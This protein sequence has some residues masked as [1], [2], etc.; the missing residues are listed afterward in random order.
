M[1]PFYHVVRHH[2]SKVSS[3]YQIIYSA[4]VLNLDFPDCITE[5]V[6]MAKKGGFYTEVSQR[7]RTLIPSCS[8][9]SHYWK[10]LFIYYWVD[11]GLG[12]GS[13]VKNKCHI[14]MCSLISKTHTHMSTCTRKRT[15]TYVCLYTKWKQ[16]GLFDM[17]KWTSGG[18]C[19][20][21]YEGKKCEQSTTHMC[22]N[23]E[24]TCYFVCLFKST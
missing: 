20:E 11:P 2:L 18:S 17:R 6:N 4:C 7:V 3:L 8:C 9:H 5:A 22:E 19:G 1:F 15:H 13:V 21:A 10:E 14:I 23:H 24:K 16:K 12:D